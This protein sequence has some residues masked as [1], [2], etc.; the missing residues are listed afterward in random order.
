MD[1]IDPISKVAAA[2][3]PEAIELA[4]KAIPKIV[5]IVGEMLP[6]QEV[7]SESNHNGFKNQ[8][9]QDL[10]E[11]AHLLPVDQGNTIIALTDPSLYTDKDTALGTLLAATNEYIHVFNELGGLTET[12]KSNYSTLFGNIFKDVISSLGLDITIEDL[13]EEAAGMRDTV[14]GAATLAQDILT[15]HRRGEKEPPNGRILPPHYLEAVDRLQKKRQPQVQMK[16]A[17]GGGGGPPGPPGGSTVINQ[18]E[19]KAKKMKYEVR[20]PSAPPK[21]QEHISDEGDRPL[22]DMLE[23]LKSIRPDWIRPLTNL[24]GYM[25]SPTVT[26]DRQQN[27]QIQQATRE[28]AREGAI[29]HRV[30]S[31]GVPVGR[32]VTTPAS[33]TNLQLPSTNSTKSPQ[34]KSIPVTEQIITIGLTK[35][36]ENLVRRSLKG[37]Q[38]ATAPTLATRIQQLIDNIIDGEV[39]KVGKMH[40]GSFSKGETT[41]KTFPP[42]KSLEQLLKVVT[43]KM[44]LRNRAVFDLSIAGDVELNPGPFTGYS[45]VGDVEYNELDEI[46]DG[47]PKTPLTIAALALQAAKYGAGLDIRQSYSWNGP[48]NIYNDNGNVAFGV[49]PIQPEITTFPITLGTTTNNVVA[50]VVGDT[51]AAFDILVNAGYNSAGT[52]NNNYVHFHPAHMMAMPMTGMALTLPVE[53]TKPMTDGVVNSNSNWTGY[54]A[55]GITL[56]TANDLLTKA[57]RLG[58]QQ[59]MKLNMVTHIAKLLL[60]GFQGIIEN[61]NSSIDDLNRWN[62]YSTT[63]PINSYVPPPYANPTTPVQIFGVANDKFFPRER[64]AYANFTV[65]FVSDITATGAAAPSIN[66]ASNLTFVAPIPNPR[67]LALYILGA[68]PY[69]FFIPL[70]T[71]ANTLGADGVHTFNNIQVIHPASLASFEGYKT[72]VINVGNNFVTGGPGGGAAAPFN[73]A[74]FPIVLGTQ[75]N[76]CDYLYSWF[77]DPNTFSAIYQDTFNFW[78]GRMGMTS[79]YIEAWHIA[80]EVAVVYQ[81]QVQANINA[82][83]TTLNS[84]SQNRLASEALGNDTSLTYNHMVYASGWNP[85][86]GNGSFGTQT[87]FRDFQITSG[88]YRMTPR[89][90]YDNMAYVLAGVATM[91]Q[92][93]ADNAYWGTWPIDVLLRVRARI[94]ANGFDHVVA[95]YGATMYDWRNVNWLQTLQLTEGGSTIFYREVQEYA[96]SLSGFKLPTDL[97]MITCLSGRINPQPG[98][99]VKLFGEHGINANGQKTVQGLMLTSFQRISVTK[100]GKLS[101][102]TSLDDSREKSFYMKTPPISPNNTNFPLTLEVNDMSLLSCS[103]ISNY[104]SSLAVKVTGKYMWNAYLYI[105]AQPLGVQ[106]LNFYFLDPDNNGAFTSSAGGGVWF[107]VA[108]QFAQLGAGN[109]FYGSSKYMPYKMGG[110]I[111]T[112]TA[113]NL[114]GI[115]RINSGNMFITNVKIDRGMTPIFAGSMPI[116]GNDIKVIVMNRHKKRK[117][118]IQSA[119]NLITMNMAAV[120]GGE[121]STGEKLGKMELE[122]SKFSTAP[123]QPAVGGPTTVEIAK[124]DGS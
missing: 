106:S 65:I 17:S 60:Y 53:K 22:L 87:F 85:R 107:P 57:T 118:E 2:V 42:E 119:Q 116:T 10:A 77:G 26:Q 93:L 7:Q 46:I 55:S 75:Y 61:R 23:Q 33:Q 6:Q 50:D 124:T 103:Q 29:D 84:N 16:V 86:G 122:A 3:G 81:P 109:R 100:E 98:F 51:A 114:D 14:E 83:G 71:L 35:E 117:V 80:A 101:I 82:F 88:V 43:A 20:T 79:Q 115:S 25:R 15:T 96:E 52:A 37:E 70:D 89:P 63:V 40:I 113:T 47:D 27:E 44:G 97:G 48:R 28:R 62:C 94:V 30:V 21:E 110:G 123:I 54:G 36:E 73:V 91:D 49:L 19:E 72:L 69:P 1:N 24:I 68:V 67:D 111:I 8:R 41:A 58:M 102:L 18:D 76:L 121:K 95:S 38:I 92:E 34:Q 13:L 45:Q 31:A 104:L 4:G 64:D 120:V 59:T 56:K 32:T 5:E 90:T 11:I 39:F 9:A 112:Y 78:V 105:K 66:A 108:T 99:V 12:A 74:N